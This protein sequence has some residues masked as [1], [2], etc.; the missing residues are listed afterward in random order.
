[1][2]DDMIVLAH[3][4]S[5]SIIFGGKWN[6]SD[7]LVLLNWC[8]DHHSV[9][10]YKNKTKFVTLCYCGRCSTVVGEGDRFCNQCGRALR[11]E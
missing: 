7:A 10:V 8:A 1:M 2:P 9:K 11:W 3:D 5:Q 4:L 6:V